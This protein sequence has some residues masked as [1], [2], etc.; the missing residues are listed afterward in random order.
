[1]SQQY[2]T[3]NNDH[4]QYISQLKML[5]STAKWPLLPEYDSD[6]YLPACDLMELDSYLAGCFQQIT[7]S[8]QLPKE[9]YHLLQLDEDLTL[10]LAFST[11]S[12]KDEFVRY[13]NILDRCIILAR[14]A[15]S[16]N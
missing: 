11:D 4:L 8:T 3:S 10:R 16:L 2:D 9:Y 7:D 12:R 5:W 13:K 6:L 1:M 14:K 15:L